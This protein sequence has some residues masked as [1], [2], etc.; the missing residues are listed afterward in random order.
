MHSQ[1]ELRHRHK[2]FL[3][4]KEGMLLVGVNDLTLLGDHRAMWRVRGRGQGQDYQV[5]VESDR[6]DGNLQ[7]VS[8]LHFLNKICKLLHNL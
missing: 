2:A 8:T 7:D 5:V 6:Q 1:M 4:R 3:L